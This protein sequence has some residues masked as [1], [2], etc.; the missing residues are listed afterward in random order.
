MNRPRA[1]ALASALVAAVTATML[2]QNPDI[3]AI[4]DFW[5]GD[6]TGAAAAIRDAGLQDKVK[7]ITT[8][9][10]E[11]TADCE[12]IDNGTY[13]AVVM[14]D[15]KGQSRDISAL[16]K[17]LLQSGLKPGQAK[18]WIYTLETATTKA[19]LKPGTC[20]SLKDV[21]AAEAALAK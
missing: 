10:G 7:L 18:S 20:W 2:Q 4:I 3:C 17:F 16:L 5:D 11:Q 15:V 9:G 19:D 12:M 8:G 1:F 6:A 13:H 21:Q 14:T